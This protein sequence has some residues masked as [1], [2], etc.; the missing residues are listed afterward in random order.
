MLCLV[1]IKNAILIEKAL[2]SF[3]DEQANQKIDQKHPKKGLFFEF[4]HKKGQDS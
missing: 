2:E 4:N 3:R 1:L